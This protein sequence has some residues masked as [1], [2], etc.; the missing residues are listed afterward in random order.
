MNQGQRLTAAKRIQTRLR[1]I[2]METWIFSSTELHVMKL[3][4]K[5]LQ[6]SQFHFT[7]N[8]KKLKEKHLLALFLCAESCKAG[9]NTQYCTTIAFQNIEN[10]KLSIGNIVSGKMVAHYMVERSWSMSFE[11]KWNSVRSQ[12]HF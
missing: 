6:Y 2:N 5:G 11:S 4:W 9:F 7:K 10:H 12:A 1:N 3:S 8:V